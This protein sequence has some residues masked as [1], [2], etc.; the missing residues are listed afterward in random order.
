[1]D[2]ITARDKGHIEEIKTALSRV[3]KDYLINLSSEKDWLDGLVERFG[4]D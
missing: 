3:E 2:K 4:K 1:M